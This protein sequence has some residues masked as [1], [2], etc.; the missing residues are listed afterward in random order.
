MRILMH[1]AECYGVLQPHSGAFCVE[2]SILKQRSDAFCENYGILVKHSETRFQ[3]GII[4]STS[5]GALTLVLC[6]SMYQCS[7]KATV[8]SHLQ[9]VRAM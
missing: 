7:K 3:I 2:H 8:A 6:C 4:L 5:R 1:S 9:H